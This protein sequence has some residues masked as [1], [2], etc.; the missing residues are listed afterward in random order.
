MNS[1]YR[2]HGS[3][4]EL[5]TEA[6]FCQ[7]SHQMAVCYTCSSPFLSPVLLSLSHPPY[8][9]F[10]IQVY[11]S[12]LHPS[13]KWTLIT[14]THT[15]SNEAKVETRMTT[16]LTMNFTPPSPLPPP[17]PN[18]YTLLLP[19]QHEALLAA[20]AT[21]CCHEHSVVGWVPGPWWQSAVQQVC[22][23]FMYFRGQW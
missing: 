21:F 3:S 19:L 18:M 13:R 8:S 9:P 11:S 17:P 6:P 10:I 15:L 14:F 23:I 12:W 16:S 2:I 22:K 20:T 7:T 1:Q 4:I 5:A